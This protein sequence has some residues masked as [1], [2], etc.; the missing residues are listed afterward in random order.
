[1]ARPERRLHRRGH[2]SLPTAG[3][4][5]A[6]GGGFNRTGQQNPSPGTAM[7]VESAPDDR[8]DPSG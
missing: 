6:V 1:M 8:D 7:M 3:Y 5:L 4:P 2:G